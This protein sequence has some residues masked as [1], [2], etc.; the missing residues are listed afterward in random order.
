MLWPPPGRSAYI[1]NGFAQGAGRLEIYPHLLPLHDGQGF[2]IVRI[3]LSY[4][5]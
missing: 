4:Q 1:A 3:S 2:R 5:S